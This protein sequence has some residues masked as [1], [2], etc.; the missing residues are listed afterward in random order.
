MASSDDK[1]AS[2]GDPPL[3]SA[4][5][6]F[7]APSLLAAYEEAIKAARGEPLE[8][9][10]VEPQRGGDLHVDGYFEEL[11]GPRARA[12]AAAEETCKGDVRRRLGA[13]PP[14]L[15]AT[16]EHRGPAG[17]VQEIKTRGWDTISINWHNNTIG[18]RKSDLY[19][20]N[21]YIR[22]AISDIGLGGKQASEEPLSL[23]VLSP[24]DKP[25]ES[26]EPLVAT[27]SWVC[28]VGSLA[29]RAR[30]A[31]NYLADRAENP[32]P[33][34]DLAK[35]SK[36]SAAAKKGEHAGWR[37]W[38]EEACELAGEEVNERTLGSVKQ[39][40]LQWMKDRVALDDEKEARSKAGKRKREGQ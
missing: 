29:H 38:E 34:R 1:S 7:A 25:R 5:R 15:I 17:T 23:V 16:G 18:R 12:A 9:R 11:G 20:V 4:W 2:Y 35:K 8:K 39:A 33:W 31:F 10:W 30:A 3:S 28:P 32:M 13:S 36:A 21:V 6:K 27:A 19:W 26:G 24:N 14:S 37:P 22:E 40:R